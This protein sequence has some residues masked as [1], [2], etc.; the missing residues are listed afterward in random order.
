MPDRRRRRSP[1]R[2][3]APLA[4]L[5]AAVA[6]LVVVSNS[7]IT[8]GDDSSDSATTTEQTATERT[9]TTGPGR[10]PRRNYR[11]RPGDSFGSIA[12]RTGV[13]VEQL[14][15]LNPEVDPQALVV[16]QRIKLRE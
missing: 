16:G 14:Q 9:T 6:V 8:S 11:V 15:L 12:E 5:L 10:R 3:I 7:D 1:F 4:L 2:Y 13:S